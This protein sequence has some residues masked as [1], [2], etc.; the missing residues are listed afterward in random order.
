MKSGLQTEQEQRW[1]D[2]GQ[3]S[4]VALSPAVPLSISLALAGCIEVA[5]I[6]A[7]MGSVRK[8]ADVEDGGLRS[9]CRVNALIVLRLFPLLLFTKNFVCVF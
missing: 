5:V 4:L 9:N 7:V 6:S 3:I 2:D 8:T 1:S